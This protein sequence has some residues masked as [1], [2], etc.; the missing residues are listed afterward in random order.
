MKKYK[1]ILKDLLFSIAVLALTFLMSFLIQ[2]IFKT[3]TLVPT[4]FVLGV[5]FVS[6]KTEGYIWGVI[7]SFG[8]L[9]EASFFELNETF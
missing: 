6:L 3:D 5:F 1:L 4:I 7:V 9:N 2:F 8:K